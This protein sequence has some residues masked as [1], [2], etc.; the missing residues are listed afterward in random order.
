MVSVRS[1][2]KD[3]KTYSFED[4]AKVLSLYLIGVETKIERH[5]YLTKRA[6]RKDVEIVKNL[7][8]KLNEETRSTEINGFKL[9]LKYRRALIGIARIELFLWGVL[10]NS[11]D[12]ICKEHKDWMM[13]KNIHRMN[14]DEILASIWEL[15]QSESGFVFVLQERGAK[16]D[17]SKYFPNGL[18]ADPG[19]RSGIFNLDVTNFSELQ[20]VLLG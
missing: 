9:Q 8:I 12:D 4:K 13:E 1:L 19:E 10:N 6:V 2:L 15:E 16:V 17:S 11:K 18:A 20:D 7:L 3:W 14:K 5:D